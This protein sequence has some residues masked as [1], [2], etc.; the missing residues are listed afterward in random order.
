LAIGTH[1][2]AK[3]LDD[4][5]V[6]KRIKRWSDLKDAWAENRDAIDA[7]KRSDDNT[8]GP[9]DFLV[10][11]E[12]LVPADIE[13][14]EV[15]D[16]LN[17]SLLYIC[18]ARNNNVELTLETRA[19]KK[20]FYEYLRSALPSTMVDRIEWKTNDGGEIKVRDIIALAWIPLSVIDLPVDIKIPPQNIYRNK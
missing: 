20:G 13:R 17:A 19:N 5:R 2:L 9:L 6:L 3:A 7:L 4:D 12:V 18:A 1:V 8:D 14:D 11:I 16:A 15:V 10:P